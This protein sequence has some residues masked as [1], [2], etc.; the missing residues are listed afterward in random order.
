MRSWKAHPDAR[1]FQPG[2]HYVESLGWSRR[3][4]QIRLLCRRS[5]Q[6]LHGCLRVCLERSLICLDT[7]GHECGNT[8]PTLQFCPLSPMNHHAPLVGRLSWYMIQ[9]DGAWS[10]HCASSLGVVCRLGLVIRWWFPKASREYRDRECLH[11][12]L[13][14]TNDCGGLAESIN[15]DILG[16]WMYAYGQ[17]C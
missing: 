3:A 7:A 5:G 8:T 11:P 12:S 16:V 1:Y 2:T 17:L 14:G 9:D 6:N 4:S 10:A 13:E 15:I